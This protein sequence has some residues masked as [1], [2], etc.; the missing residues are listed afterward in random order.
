MGLWLRGLGFRVYG[1]R[2]YGGLGLILSG[3]R[4][5]HGNQGLGLSRD[6]GSTGA[7]KANVFNLMVALK[8]F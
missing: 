4:R 5:S 2:V 6:F 7:F 3:T 1:F 8:A